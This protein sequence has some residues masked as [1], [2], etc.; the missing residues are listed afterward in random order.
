MMSKFNIWLLYI[1][2]FKIVFIIKIVNKIVSNI[3]TL[4][5]DCS[6]I[7][8]KILSSIIE[9]DLPYYSL[10]FF[11]FLIFKIYEI[12]W[13]LLKNTDNIQIFNRF[14]FA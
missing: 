8:F 6:S 5:I 1:S 12:Y 4:G 9:K 7:N 14:N 13:K 3:N 11:L 10:L 2:S